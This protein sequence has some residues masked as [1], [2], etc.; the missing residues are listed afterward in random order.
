[1]G[2]DRGG[3]MGHL[4][5]LDLSAGRRYRLDGDF[6]GRRWERQEEAARKGFN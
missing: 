2:D 6:P 1:M 3:G 5:C 4:T